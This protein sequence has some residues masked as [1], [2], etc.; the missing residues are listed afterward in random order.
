MP[1]PIA[2]LLLLLLIEPPKVLPVWTTLMPTFLPTP[3]G[4]SMVTQL[5]SES[6]MLP[7]V[8]LG[9]SRTAITLSVIRWKLVMGSVSPKVLTKAIAATAL[10]V[11]VIAA[12]A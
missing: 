8:L 6:G 10:L 9:L 7:T 4:T 1:T 3:A 5:E 2:T 12:A 11:G